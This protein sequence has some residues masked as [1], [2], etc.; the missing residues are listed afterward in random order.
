VERL[1]RA[2]LQTSYWVQGDQPPGAVV[3]ASRQ[4]DVARALLLLRQLANGETMSPASFSMSV[5]NALGALYS[6]ANAYTEP[7]TA[8]AAGENTVE[9]AFM[10]ALGQLA[11]GVP[12]VLL[13]YY[14]EPL[15]PP[16]GIFD[17]GIA[18]ARACAYRLSL[19][20]TG[21]FSLHAAARAPDSEIQNTASLPA[22]LAVF[23]FLVNHGAQRLVRT[24]GP[25]QWEWSRHDELA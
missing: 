16:Y 9:A 20:Q 15:P 13:V 7:Y 5:H 11:D 17:D 14:D 21:G 25:R 24:V 8:I 3:F 4:G 22:D 23:D 19:A 6:I 12:D 10:E 18:F 1:G 2:A